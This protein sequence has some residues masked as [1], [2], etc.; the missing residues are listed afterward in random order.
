VSLAWSAL[1]AWQAWAGGLTAPL[2]AADVVL[3]CALC[4]AQPRLVAEE[5]L[6][7]GV[8]WIAGL[9]TMSIVVANFAWRPAAAV[10][11]GVLVAAAHLAGARLADA[12]D[13]GYTTAGIQ[14]VQVAATAALMAVLR[15][16]VRDA[17]DVLAASRQA[18]RATQAG[19]A[20]RAEEREQNRR[21]H[22][23]VL[24]TLT[25]VG[26]GTLAASTAILRERA[27]AELA[28]IEQAAAEPHQ[29][30]DV[31]L[32]MYLR[33]RLDG[34]SVRAG[35]SAV[36]RRVPASVAAA[37]AAA[38]AEALTNVQRHSPGAGVTVDVASA[39]DGVH[40]AIADD[41]PGFDPE[42]VPAHRYGIREAI[43]GRMRGA[44]G[45]AVITSGPAGTT[46]ALRWGP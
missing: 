40:V 16:A 28:M 17:D 22:D 27:A 41:G 44:G 12:A 42:A 45:D 9:A 5:I 15:R 26:T 2:M 1:F 34:R 19:L 38:A 18:E 3:T 11:A 35:R 20:R 29:D 14:L 6:P 39:T 32:L 46:V 33:A 24:A 31:D 25:T 8:S 36:G 43:V 23:T 4:L 30:E 10:P 21:T 13:G 37:F 7:G